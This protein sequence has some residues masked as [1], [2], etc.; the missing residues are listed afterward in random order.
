MATD[1]DMRS[2]AGGH[3]FPRAVALLAGVF[4]V[5][6]G[7]W[8]M[9]APQGFFDAAAGFD[10][11]NQHFLQDIGAFM[12][13]IGAVLLLAV[14]MPGRGALGVALLGSGIGLALHTVSHVIGRDLGGDPARDIA[15]QGLLTVLLLAAAVVR[16]RETA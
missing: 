13:G 3:W 1:G 16:F 4:L 8:A 6:S 7:L 2:A 10:P 14:T 9:A 11:Y 5:G 12:A 15:T